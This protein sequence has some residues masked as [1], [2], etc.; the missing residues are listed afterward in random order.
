[1][2]PKPIDLDTDRALALY[3]QGWTLQEI[4]TAMGC[5]LQTVWR[6]LRAARVTLRKP[7]QGVRHAA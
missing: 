2:P 1:M 5:S 4:G 6:R 3:R 7:N